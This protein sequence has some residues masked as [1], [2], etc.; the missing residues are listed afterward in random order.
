MGHNSLTDCLCVNTYFFSPTFKL[1]K[2][3][4]YY[5]E[6][7]HITYMLDLIYFRARLRALVSF[8]SSSNWIF[9]K[10]IRFYWISSFRRIKKV[11]IFVDNCIGK[12]NTSTFPNN[13]PF[14]MSSLLLF[15]TK[16]LLLLNNRE[17]SPKISK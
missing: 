14:W 2:R 9:S 15:N 10:E 17:Y 13:I 4:I 5:R 1:P 7:F 6:T 12:V 8:Y 11:D 16:Y 3:R